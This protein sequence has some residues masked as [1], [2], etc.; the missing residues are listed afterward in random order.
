MPPRKLSLP[1]EEYHAFAVTLAQRAGVIMRKHFA[2]A[3][4]SFTMKGDN[5]P[6]TV[7]D[8]SINSMVIKAVAK[9]FSSHSVLGEEESSAQ[10][11]PQLWVCDPIDGTFP[12]T[13]GIPTSTF[14][15]AYV[16]DGEPLVAV[17]FD[18]FQKRMYSAI[19]GK[20]AWLGERRL[21]L[22]K[23][24]AKGR[25]AV[26][27][28]LWCGEKSVITDP[29]CWPTITSKLVAMNQ[30]P[31]YLCGY[32]FEAV[33][34]ASG[35]FNG[36]V[37][38]GRSPWDGAAVGLIGQEAGAVVTDLLGRQ[39]RYDGNIFGQIIARPDWH[40]PLL[41]LMAPYVKEPGKQRL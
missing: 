20:G 26:S 3:A 27:A 17:T 19:R 8:T 39:Q 25:G 13:H 15:L 16:H 21:K 11:S 38:G 14:N 10:V 36:A 18:P 2:T 22:K 34:V 40:Q 29:K 9:S 24:G 41:D 32:A 35:E 37:F 6:L 1:L 31:V 12:F 28:E 30:F 5:T 7:A 4:T 33:L 23:A